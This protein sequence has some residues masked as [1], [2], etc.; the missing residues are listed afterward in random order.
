VLN[1]A[2]TRQFRGA[3]V[4]TIA[5]AVTDYGTW[6]RCVR[7][8]LGVCNGADKVGC[9]GSI[10]VAKMAACIRNSRTGPMLS[11]NVAEDWYHSLAV[12]FVALRRTVLRSAPLR[13]P[14]E[15]SRLELAEHKKVG[16]PTIRLQYNAGPSWRRPPAWRARPG[17][18]DR[19]NGA[20]FEVHVRRFVAHHDVG[21]AKLGAAAWQRR[22]TRSRQTPQRHSAW[23]FKISAT[24]T[25]VE[26]GST[27][28]LARGPD[29]DNSAVGPSRMLR[30]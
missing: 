19:P 10:A 25:G 12:E 9:G 8:C 16:V 20:G 6:G 28:P 13:R 30:T 26:V 7:A 1:N 21:Q 18:T 11:I 27:W 22:A 15:Q 14:E 17:L 29:V 3:C 2:I 24:G 5:V 23:M 4:L